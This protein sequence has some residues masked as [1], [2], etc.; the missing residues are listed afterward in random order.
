VIRAVRAVGRHQIGDVAQHEDL[1]RHGVED[2]LR[3]GPALV[4]VNLM[5]LPPLF[6][7]RMSVFVSAIRPG[8]LLRGRLC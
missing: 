4:N 3:R 8:Y 5:P 1:A 7:F 2:G 6:S